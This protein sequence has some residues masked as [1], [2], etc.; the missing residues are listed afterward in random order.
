M[1]EEIFECKLCDF[2]SKIEAE[3]IE[4]TMKEHAA[5]QDKF[6]SK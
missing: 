1:N 5:S 6:L 4:H 2:T 3:F